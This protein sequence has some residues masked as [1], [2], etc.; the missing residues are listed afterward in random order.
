[1]KDGIG[2]G[3]TRA[4]HPALSNQLFAAYSRVKDARSLSAVIG[5]DE[6]SETDRQYLRF[7]ELFEEKFLTQSTQE[8]RSLEE[9][10]NLGW[11]LLTIL[12]RSELDRLD[13]ATIAA[14]Y[15]D[16]AWQELTDAKSAS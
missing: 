10:L 13:E 12:P 16:G 15:V 2:E 1:M 4:D 5:E 7:G 14:H 11:K 8:N 6:L 3:Y 9:T